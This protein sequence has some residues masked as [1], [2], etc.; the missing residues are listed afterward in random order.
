MKYILNYNLDLTSKKAEDYS[1]ENFYGPQKTVRTS[2]SDNA[3]TSKSNG[4]VFY[5]QLSVSDKT[6]N[7]RNYDKQSLKDNVIKGDWTK[8]YNKPMLRNHDIYEQ[9]FGRI[10]SAWFIDHEDMKVYNSPEDIK[11]DQKVIDFY[12]GKDAFKEGSGSTIIAFTADDYTADRI[13]NGL[14][15][16][17]SQSSYIEKAKCNICGEDF[18]GGTCMHHAGASYTVKDGD[19]EVEK[20]CIVYCSDFEPIETSI[21]N[22]PANNT[23]IIFYNEDSKG[24]TDGDVNHKTNVTTDSQKTNNTDKTKDSDNGINKNKEMEELMFK[25][26]LKKT[27]E[28]T[29]DSINPEEQFKETFNKLFD[30]LEKEEQT[31]ALLDFID[32]IPAK[33]EVKS[34]DEDEKNEDEKA[35]D[36]SKEDKTVEDEAKK[37]VDTEESKAEP[38]AE[39]KEEPKVEPEGKPETEENSDEET[40][41]KAKT[42]NDDT[43]ENNLNKVF[44][45]NNKETAKANTSEIL[46]ALINNLE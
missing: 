1:F 6:I 25:D 44:K 37:T 9:A 12:I 34:T 27:L 41:K 42:D 28:K 21:V 29:I 20:V 4:E 32:G 45:D 2:I 13:K 36:D 22:A 40:A 3:F 24:D 11:L 43:F 23:S 19:T 38:K 31:K 10:Q 5:A 7:L 26:L 30:S 15:N 17:I 46:N 18:F 35:D 16:T 39:P 14:D 8:P 33:V